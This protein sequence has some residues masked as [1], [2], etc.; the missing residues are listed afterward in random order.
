M[1]ISLD[2]AFTQVVATIADYNG[3]LA[4]VGPTGA[5]AVFPFQADTTYY[6]RVRASLPVDGPYSATRSFKIDALKPLALSAPASGA[7]ERFRE[8]DLRVGPCYWCD[9]LRNRG[10]R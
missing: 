2:S 5:A 7:I 9:D 10:L 4:I 1:Q 3:V 6:W 8:A